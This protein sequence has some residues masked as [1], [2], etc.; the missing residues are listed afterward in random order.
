MCFCSVMFPPFKKYLNICQKK[1][2]NHQMGPGWMGPWAIWSSTWSSSWQPCPCDMRVGTWWSLRSLPT[3]ATLW[4][5][6]IWFPGRI[7][8]GYVWQLDIFIIQI[9]SKKTYCAYRQLVVIIMQ[10]KC[11]HL[12]FF[13]SS[14]SLNSLHAD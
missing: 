4:F 14:F 3:Q 1:S 6:A 5:C 10:F 8:W 13:S 12:F 9:T 7:K 11:Y 2:A